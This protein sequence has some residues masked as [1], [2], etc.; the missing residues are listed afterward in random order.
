MA[1][2][3]EKQRRATK[4]GFVR[5]ET[6][7]K[8][9][10]TDVTTPK[11][12]IQRRFVD[13]ECNYKELEKAH[14]SYIEALNA[15]AVREEEEE[16]WLTEF[17]TRFHNLEVQYD[18]RMKEISKT[19]IDAANTATTAKTAE[20]KKD[21]IVKLERMKF[22]IF[23][24]NIRKYPK[25]KEDFNIHIKPMCDPTQI[26]FV[27]KSY[28]SEELREDVDCLGENLTEIWER[29]DRRFG[30]ESRLVDTILADVKAIQICGNDD[31]TLSMIKTMERCYADLKAMGRELEMNDTTIISTE[32]CDGN[33]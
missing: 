3:A 15:D 21:N 27:L 6:L 22:N 17:T 9:S 7:L 10:L 11:D 1:D 14:D 25:F 30:N 32:L 28:L 23:D 18:K 5:A 8:T 33:D 16:A 26:P 19:E 2:A 13:L 29:L 24:G 12:T 31:N 20:P 4:R